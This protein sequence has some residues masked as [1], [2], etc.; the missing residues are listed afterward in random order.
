MCCAPAPR[1][2]ETPSCTGGSCGHTP[3]PAHRPNPP[4]SP[5]AP[6]SASPGDRAAAVAAPSSATSGVAA[7][8]GRLGPPPWLAG[9]FLAPALILLGLLVVYPILY[10]IW[11]SLYDADGETFVA[12]DNYVAIF[13]DSATFQ[14]LKNNAIWVAVAV[15]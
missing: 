10:T 14:A 11:R 1:S 15:T 7:G 6:A 13:T 3:P 2:T 12:L 8:K 9:G 4:G 5:S